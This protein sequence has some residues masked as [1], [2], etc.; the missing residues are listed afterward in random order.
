MKRTFWKLGAGAVGVGVF[1]L[2]LGT[3]L[4]L[5]PKNNLRRL[6]YTPLGL[7][8]GVSAG[9]ILFWVGVAVAVLGAVLILAA[10]VAKNTQGSG[11]K[12]SAENPML[13]TEGPAVPPEPVNPVDMQGYQPESDDWR[14]DS[15]GAVNP[16][17]YRFCSVCGTPRADAGD[18]SGGN[19]F[20]M[21]GNL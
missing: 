15:C 5:T 12:K 16:A 9:D 20:G 3:I 10:L 11:K 8:R 2:L 4:R 17:A 18:Y 6:F 7:S 13:W 19:G 21:P 1:T 14:C